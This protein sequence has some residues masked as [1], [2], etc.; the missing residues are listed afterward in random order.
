MTKENFILNKSSIDG[1]NGWCKNCTKDSSLCNRYN[2]SLEDYKKLL[3]LQ[4]EQCFL[5]GT[6][7]PMGPTNMFVVDHCHKTG[8]IRGLLCNHC[9]TGI[10]K[11]H[12]DPQLLRKAA[13]Y[14]EATLML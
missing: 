11:L 13:D 7:D 14:I 6:N 9:N 1:F 10:G 5:C 2:I 3:I 8:K 4:N 12:D